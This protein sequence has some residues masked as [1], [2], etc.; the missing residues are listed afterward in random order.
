M[1]KTHDFP[2]PTSYTVRLDA[3]YLAIRYHM[4]ERPREKPPISAL[5][6][7]AEEIELWLWKISRSTVAE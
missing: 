3:L 4:I 5:L 6:Y 2:P 7:D 1:N